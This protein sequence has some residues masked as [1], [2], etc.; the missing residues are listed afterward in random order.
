MGRVLAI[1]LGTKR[2]G[3]AVTDPLMIV[4]SPLETIP[5]HQ[6]LEYLKRYTNSEEVSTIV[7][8]WPKSLDGTAT[9][10]TQPVLA[11]EKKLK[12]TFP[13]IPVELVDER[14]TSKMAMQSMINMG[15]KKKDRK[16][17]AGNLDK[18]SAAI[19]L[20]TYLDRK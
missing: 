4:A 16:E 11:L 6:L 19:I 13:A 20:Q 7:L 18:I 10:M 8:G 1:D 5:T 9:N 3:L 2:T 14:F 12:K 15:S 17:K